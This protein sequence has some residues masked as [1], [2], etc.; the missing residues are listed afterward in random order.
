MDRLLAR[1]LTPHVGKQR[2]A[3]T[4]AGMPRMELPPPRFV[5]AQALR[6]G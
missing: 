4:R 1:K 5:P 2:E 3:P 6:S